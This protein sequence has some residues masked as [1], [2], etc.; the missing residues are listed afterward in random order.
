MNIDV[1]TY[2]PAMIVVSRLRVEENGRQEIIGPGLQPLLRIGHE[3]VSSLN[4]HENQ[5]SSREEPHLLMYE[6]AKRNF[7]SKLCYAE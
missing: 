5:A 1:L 6:N 2:Y 7:R 3:R 4:A